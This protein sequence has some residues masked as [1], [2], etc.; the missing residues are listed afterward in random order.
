MV[1]RSLLGLL[2]L[3]V[4][5]TAVWSW[6]TT[7]Y[8]IQTKLSSAGGTL[9]VRDNAPQSGSGSLAFTNFTTSAPVPVTV[10]ANTGYNISSLSK[11][12]QLLALGNYT[13]NYLTSFVKATGSTQS[14]VA[15]FTA[16]RLQVSSFV[17]GSGTIS[18]ASYQINYGGSLNLSAAPSFTNTAVT[19]IT[20]NGAPYPA[21][22]PSKTQVT[23]GLS[24]VTAPVS[25]AATFVTLTADAGANQYIQLNNPVTLLGAA[26][27]G[28]T[29]SWSQQSGPPVTLSSS[30]ALT[31]SFLPTSTGS[32]QFTL[33]ESVN[34]LVLATSSVQVTVV[35]SLLDYMRSSCLGCHA[36]T[37]VYPA[38]QTFIKWSSSAHKSAFVSCMSCHGNSAM[39][40]P[41]NS[42][43]VDKTSFVNLYASAGPVGSSYCFAACHHKGNNLHFNAEAQLANLCSACHNP[44]DHDGSAAMARSLGAQHFNGYT[45]GANS[46][47]QAAYVT[48][49]APC[50][51][52]HLATIAGAPD[53]GRDPALLQQRT[54]WAASGHGDTTGAGLASR[55][56]KNLS[57]CVQ[58]H[59]APGFIAFST[60]KVTGAWGTTSDKS[61]G[62]LSCDACHS[63]LST[64]KLRAAGPLQPYAG[65]SYTTPD[66]SSSNLCVQCHSGVQSGRSIKAL[67]AAHAD[68][69]NQAFI[70]SHSSAAGIL[71]KSAGYQFAFRNYSNSWHFKHDRIG[72]GNFS[73]YG[74]DTGSAG[75]CVGCHMS[76]SNGHSF[77]PVSRDAVG[78]IT[79]ITSASCGSCHSG[80]AYL[81]A[82]RMNARE[83]KYAAALFALQRVLETRGIYYANVAPYFFKSAGSSDPANAVTNWGN[84]DTMGAAFNFNLL[85]HEAGAYAH[86]MIYSKR[87]IYDSID[88]LD[89]GV[90]DNSV[91]AT[92]NG[93]SGLD[94]AQK[95]TALGY[96]VGTGA[97]P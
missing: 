43:T 64:G 70:G 19:A 55:D 78:A 73:A 41:V 5:L 50:A 67:A 48:P 26:T 32:Y 87:L 9:R 79:Q 3:S 27:G 37:G 11:N 33:S 30:S 36:A 20:V 23:I 38:P 90:L 42:S 21:T 28:G 80:P 72:E 83:A 82:G 17:T 18:P 4:V 40:T 86:N 49:A 24:N 45:S 69:S 68:F 8:Q 46:K 15:G 54:D 96:L 77:R 52:C 1:K 92:V 22:L 2:C 84:A 13:A 31:P 75:P 88:F 47:L 10:A 51:A 58:C 85:Q 7:V 97:R 76:S 60:A 65:D 57:G 29:A 94:A 91:S 14:L 44:W 89:N 62:V 93:L 25:V 63:D 53:S 71:F 59:T 56:F 16:K 35:A 81:D 61:R 74:Y 39:P 12:G 6:A 66:L 95:G 34:G